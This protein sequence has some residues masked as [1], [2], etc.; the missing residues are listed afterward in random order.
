[1]VTPAAA[2]DL[3]QLQEDI[4][5]ALDEEMARDPRV[6]LFGEDVADCSRSLSTRLKPATAHSSMSEYPR[7]SEPS[8]TNGYDTATRRHH[9]AP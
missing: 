1:M 8:N 5:E 3:A 9:S 6:V 7:A 4:R 2:A